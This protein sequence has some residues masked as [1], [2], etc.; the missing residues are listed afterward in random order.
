MKITFTLSSSF[1]PSRSQRLWPSLSADCFAT[2]EGWGSLGCAVLRVHVWQLLGLTGWN[3]RQVCLK[4]GLKLNNFARLCPYW[5]PM[6]LPIWFLIFPG[7]RGKIFSIAVA[8]TSVTGR[9]A[10]A[11]T[12]S[13]TPIITKPTESNNNCNM[14][15][16]SR[17]LSFF[18]RYT[19][20]AALFVLLLIQNTRS[21]NVTHHIRSQCKKNQL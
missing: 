9:T 18:V 3:R 5:H 17:N 10:T 1:W 4:R 12:L 13:P 16:W 21:K 14:S 7:F 20:I 2:F 6:R 8:R 11:S 15:Q 19:K